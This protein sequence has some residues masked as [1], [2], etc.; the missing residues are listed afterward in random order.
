MFAVLSIALANLAL[1]S[2]YAIERLREGEREGERAGGREGGREA[3]TKT[4]T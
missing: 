1:V 4:K 3:K 2:V